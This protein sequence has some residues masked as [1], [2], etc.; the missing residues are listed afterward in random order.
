M[1]NWCSNRAS[2]SGP[3]PVIREIKQILESDDK[4][5]LNWMVPQPNFESDQD[6]YNW[7]VANWGTK[8]DICDVDVE[9]CNEEDSIEFS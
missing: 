1:P 9:D 5:L 8:W 3:A 6:W 7:N 2:I 4:A